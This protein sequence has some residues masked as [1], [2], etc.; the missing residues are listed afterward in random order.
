[1]LMQIL[2]SEYI[3]W[4]KSASIRFKKPGVG[5]VQAHFVLTPAQIETFRQELS[6][7]NKIEPVLLVNIVDET[8]GV[9]AVVEK[10]LHIKKKA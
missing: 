1:M 4:D 6:A 3:I 7:N 8:G 10:V 9:V 2:G 5:K